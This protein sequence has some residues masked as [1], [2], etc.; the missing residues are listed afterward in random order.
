MR[1]RTHGIH[2]TATG[3]QTTRYSA[4]DT[5]NWLG[6]GLRSLGKSS[7]WTRR[8]E[9][10]VIMHVTKFAEFGCAR[11]LLAHVQKEIFKSRSQQ[12]RPI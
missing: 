10:S 1:D 12:P 3:E 8:Q 5:V 6:H 2:G 7:S 4:S 9:Q 11:T